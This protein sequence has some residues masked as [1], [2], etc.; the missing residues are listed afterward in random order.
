[1]HLKSPR[2]TV[3]EAWAWDDRL[4]LEFNGAHPGVATLEVAKIDVP[5]VYLLGDSTVCD[6]PR[7][8]YNSWGQMLTRF[9]KP[10]VA[11][12]N[13]AESGDAIAPCSARADSTNSG[14]R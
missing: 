10:D 4:T 5:T 1:M 12:C 2:E 11:V 13:G 3:Q 6:Q 14:A 9:L 8:P 7:E